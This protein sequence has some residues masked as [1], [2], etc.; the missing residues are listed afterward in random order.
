[1][2]GDDY[3]LDPRAPVDPEVAAL[4]KALRPL[5]FQG[6]GPRERVL[7]VPPKRSLGPWPWVLVTTA[8]AAALWLWM[9][10][11][12]TDGLYPGCP[13]QTFVSEKAEMQVRLGEL[14]VITLRPESELEFVHWHD[15]KQALFR[16]K[17]GGMHADV[18]PPPLVQA[19]FFC[20][21]TDRAK[22]VDQGC[23]YDL[24][25][26]PDGTQ[27]VL[28]QSGAVTFASRTS[29]DGF[30]E[31]FVPAGARAVVG[32]DGMRTPTFLTASRE[33]KS[34][35]QQY[36]KMRRSKDQSR[37]PDI[38]QKLAAVCLD[39]ADTLPLWHL[40]QDGDPDV[41]KTATDRML[42]LVGPPGGNATK[43]PPQ[44]AEWLQYLRE[45]AW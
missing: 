42:T 1:M 8:A 6:G 19:G 34:I 27:R 35:V 38:A 11:P 43:L 45:Q 20:V 24:L 14:A 13:S 29:V 36:D 44:P 3:L 17:R 37:L 18:V 15:G 5:K 39:R 9:Q 12:T 10:W 25:T 41:A 31:V 33:V 28:V 2:S 21:D 4:E 7:A 32:P 22:V 26:S 40:L 16:L 30:R 23:S